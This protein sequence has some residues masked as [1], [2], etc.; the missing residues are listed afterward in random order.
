VNGCAPVS[1]PPRIDV[2]DLR[3]AL[4]AFYDRDRRDLPWRR[5]RDP[6]R[7][8]VSEIMLQQTRVDTAEPYYRRWIERFPT[9]DDL[10][11]ASR[12]EVLKA[13]EGLGYY[14]RARC[15]HAGALMVRER[16]GGE[17]PSSAREL[18]EL[19][20]VGEYTAGAVASI[21]FGEVTPAIDG[22]ARR[23]LARLYDIAD[24]G[25]AELRAIVE[26]LIDRERPGDFNQAVME[27]GATIC[28]PRTPTCGACPLGF[29]CRA[30]AAGTQLDRPVTKKRG[31]TPLRE[32]G[33]AIVLDPGS[34]LLLRRRPEEGLLG[35]LWEFPNVLSRTGEPSANAARR[36][37][38]E[39]GVGRV[40]SSN[41]TASGSLAPVRHTFSHFRAVYHAHVFR[42]DAARAPEACR[43]SMPTEVSDLAMPVAQRKILANWS[44]AAREK[45]LA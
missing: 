23:V 11:E 2:E 6:Y 30:R 27:L 44:S 38:A 17:I 43:W 42:T 18:R 32:F 33:V 34:R 31:K 45:I 40:E 20:G 26:E 36:A 25:P 15:I 29:V 10:A 22:N 24:P 37:A 14:S 21:A 19:P 16:F 28:T 1:S 8:W 3:S 13:W 39:A 9:L 41:R 4:F 5:D 12:D 7:I 35:G